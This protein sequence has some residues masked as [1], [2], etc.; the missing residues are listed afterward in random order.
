MINS[1]SYSEDITLL[2]GNTPLIKLRGP[3]NLTG[4][5]IL[6]KAE[7]L[8]P[9]QSIK[10]R[11]A[12]YMI[13]DAEKRNL[14]QRGGTIVEGTGGNTGIGLTVIG[15]ALGY[16]T[17][18]VMPNN[19][20]VEKIN[21]L[22]HLGAKVI[23][24]PPAPYE[25]PN[26]Y[27]KKARKISEEEGA[28]WTNQFDNVANRKAHIEGTSKEIWK[29]TNGKIDAFICAVGTGGTIGGNSIGL[30]KI[31]RRIKIYCADPMGS[32][33]YSWIKKGK[34]NPQGESITEGIGQSRITNNLK[35][36][37]IDGAFQI[38]DTEALR[39]I[40]DL[41]KNEGLFL[42]PTSGIN[43][44]GAIKLGMKLG[45]NNTIVTVLCDYGT[46][47]A[48]KVFNLKFLKERNLPTP[49]WITN[50]SS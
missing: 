39:V 45:P 31:D 47:Y 5:N 44:A 35:K 28:L 42:G 19:Q 20:S 16:K 6:G 29:Q 23:L 36:I 30:K 25:D 37:E 3:S 50:D 17:L 15:N 49:D 43:I 48:S 33:M 7:F 11:A 21:D 10:D 14:I 8:N 24:T 1:D 26:N 38:S 18:I 46:R 27:Q 12:L 34:P 13:R 4:C 40:F 41:L 22:K 9:G 2:V 32:G